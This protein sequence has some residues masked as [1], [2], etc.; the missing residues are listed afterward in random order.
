MLQECYSV[1]VF[2]CR[3]V[4]DNTRPCVAD[5]CHVLQI[6]QLEFPATLLQHVTAQAD[7]AV[8]SG[9]RTV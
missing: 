2:C 4:A 6:I 1:H 9:G 3:E 7:F 8:L 5:N